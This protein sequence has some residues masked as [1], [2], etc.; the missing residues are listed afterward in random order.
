MPF[1]C[2]FFFSLSALVAS[3]TWH[4][5]PHHRRRRHLPR[6]HPSPCHSNADAAPRSVV[7]ALPRVPAWL[8]F[9]S[10]NSRFSPF[11]LDVKRS[12]VDR[13]ETERVRRGAAPRQRA[14]GEEDDGAFQ[15]RR[16]STPICWTPAGRSEAGRQ[17]C[18]TSD[19]GDAAEICKRLADEPGSSLRR[20]RDPRLNPPT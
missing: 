2:L 8:R 16:L 5:V 1:F 9:Y 14:E 10:G 19:G 4:Q 17:A 15:E 20:R 13:E 6:G 12:R 7:L 3:V 18:R 11:L